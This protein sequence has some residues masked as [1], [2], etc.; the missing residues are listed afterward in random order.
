MEEDQPCQDLAWERCR[1]NWPG[2]RP[3]GGSRLASSRARRAWKAG[4]IADQSEGFWGYSRLADGLGVKLAVLESSSNQG[5]I[6]SLGQASF[7]FISN[8]SGGV[9]RG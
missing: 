1:W 3:E 5:C 8:K 7:G 4:R 9:I 2:Q 6:A